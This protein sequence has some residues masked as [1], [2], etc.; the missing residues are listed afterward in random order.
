MLRG[1]FVRWLRVRFSGF[2]RTIGLAVAATIAA[3]LGVGATVA[4]AGSTSNDVSTTA[5]YTATQTIATPPAADF[6]GNGGGDGWAVALT[7]S[8]PAVF[9]QAEVFNVFH[10]DSELQVACHL[11]S[12]AADCP[13][14]SDPATITDTTGAGDYANAQFASSG[15]PGLY[16]DQGTGKLYVYGTLYTGNSSEATGGV[17]CVDTTQG[18]SESDPFCGFTALTQPG[19]ASEPGIS[20]IGDGVLVGNDFYAFNYVDERTDS[21]GQNQLLCFDVATD[22]ACAG[23]PFDLGVG[24]GT[25][26]DADFPPPAVAAI[27]NEVIVPVNMGSG[28]ELAC[29][30][31]TT[32]SVCGGSFPVALGFGYN[33]SYGAPFQLLD[34]SGDLTGFCLPMGTSGPSGEDPCYDL[35]GATVATPSGLTSVISYT[36]GWNGPSVAIGPRVFVPDGDT[37]QELCFDYSTGG[38]CDA[39]DGTCIGGSEASCTPCTTTTCPSICPTNT[40]ASCTGGAFPLNMEGTALVYTVNADPQ[41]PT[42]L[43]MNSDADGG[44]LPDQIQSFDAYTGGPCGTGAIR[45]LASSFVVA[46]AACYPTSWQS[47]QVISPAPGAYD[48]GTITFENADG[49]AIPGV[50]PLT[51][52]AT[53]SANLSGISALDYGTLGELPQFLIALTSSGSEITASNVVVELTWDASYSPDCETLGATTPA[54]SSTSSSTGTNGTVTV[55]V[56]TTVPTTTTTTIKTASPTTTPTCPAPVGAVGGTA[57]G[58]FSVGM[59]QG[60]ARETLSRYHVT[61][62]R[63]DNFCL[64]HGWGIRLGYPTAALTKMLPA[65]QRARYEGHVVLALTANPFYALDGAR[66]GDTIASVAEHVHVGKPFHVGSNDWYFAVGGAETGVLKVRNGVVQEVGLASLALT[67][68]RAE[69]RVFINSFDKI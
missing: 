36:S 32:Q 23:Q 33:S 19:D 10:H 25:D 55:T 30:N 60:Q 13:W 57:V 38:A 29:W 43:W 35:T 18:A 24:S 7:G 53:G 64:Y 6:A 16:L 26:E 39:T 28:D 50:S 49:T 58:V 69:Q 63:F 51:L 62:N 47:L 68:T 34:S 45:V 48:T 3:V 8:N 65:S 2:G 5:T 67:K 31:D 12:T 40:A 27:G 42:C 59:T 41:R 20:A 4:L 14:V 9:P 44:S 66:P 11:Q 21:D 54:P 46:E 37:D 61:E 15:Q 17:I 22:A 1:R 56:T 52:D